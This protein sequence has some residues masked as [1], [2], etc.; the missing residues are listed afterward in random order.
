MTDQ[1]FPPV[2]RHLL[3]PGQPE[4]TC[5]V[6]FDELDRYVDLDLAGIDPE[7]AVPG[8]RAHLQGCPAC[9]EERRSLAALL[10][11]DQANAQ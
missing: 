7:T 11:D 4:V 10:L 2:L 5:G 6:C 8:V 9:A 3:G 1:R